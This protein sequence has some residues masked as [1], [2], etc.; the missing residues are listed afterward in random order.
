MDIS[1][2]GM[3][4][5]YW[6]GAFGANNP[7]DELWVEAQEVFGPSPLEPQIR[8]LLSIG[9]GR[10][11]LTAFGKSVIEV[12]RSIIQIAT[13]TQKTANMFPG[14]HVDLANR[15]GYFRFNPP[16]ISEV[17]LE[18]ASKR[19]IIAVRTDEYGKDHDVRAR[20]LKF[21]QVVGD[22]QSTS[23]QASLAEQEFL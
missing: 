15:D 20:M 17:G 8:G 1:R 13:Q 14:M 6:D 18:D 16:D 10:P 9:T 21:E 11:P 5:R 3:T 23:T 12:G 7:V 19:S 2:D 4:R 22:D